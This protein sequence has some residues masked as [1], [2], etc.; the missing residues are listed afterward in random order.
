[1][2]QTKTLY[3]EMY[4]NIV[5]EKYDDMDELMKNIKEDFCIEQLI[6]S[7]K[8]IDIDSFNVKKIMFHNEYQSSKK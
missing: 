1:M 2:F 4:V 7:D 5:T 6:Q 8:K 3:V